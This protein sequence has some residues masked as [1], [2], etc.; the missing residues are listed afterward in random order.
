MDARRQTLTRIMRE[1]A[2]LGKPRYQRA[3]SAVV[4]FAQASRHRA[5]HLFSPP[6]VYRRVYEIF[7]APLI[8]QRGIFL[9]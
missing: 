6:R 7:Y 2:P 8:M 4:R 1:A 3:F 9:S 5:T